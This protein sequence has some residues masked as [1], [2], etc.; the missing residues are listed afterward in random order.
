MAGYAPRAQLRLPNR[1]DIKRPLLLHQM[2]ATYEVQM[3]RKWS[4]ASDFSGS[5]GELSYTT[6]GVALGASQSA[7][8]T[9]AVTEYAVGVGEIRFTGAV[10][11]RHQIDIYPFGQIR[12]PVLH[13]RHEAE[14][15]GRPLPQQA[16]ANLGL[17]Y[18]YLATPLDSLQVRT[19]PGVVDYNNETTFVAI[20][21]RVG[22]GRRLGPLTDL[23]LDAGVFGARALRSTAAS[24]T[25][26]G[27]SRVFPVGSATVSGRLRSRASHWVDGSVT[28]AV[29][30]FFDRVR[31]RV[32]PRLR[33]QADIMVT[34]P[35]R[36]L[37]GVIF[38]AFSPLTRNPRMDVTG[39]EVFSPTLTLPRV[40]PAR[41]ELVFRAQ[42]PFTYTLNDHAAF[43][44]G[45]AVSVRS[46][47]PAARPFGFSR[48]ETWLYIAVRFAGSTARGG[49][50]INRSWPIGLGTTGLAS[51]TGGRR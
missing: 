24:S 7:L 28:T 23:S 10:A 19:E 9:S 49:E 35:P 4:L 11:P 39:V 48:L 21:N 3:S 37:M 44:I 31:E 8:P 30:G 26:A 18:T 12:T 45:T 41:D 40:A 51:G 32:E 15:N 34:L 13:S 2:Y 46:S 33:L 1:L 38:S 14:I 42:T 36:W 25:A 20:D 17:A 27:S 47:H 6:L 29:T 5:V 22:W 50:E 43:E 16:R